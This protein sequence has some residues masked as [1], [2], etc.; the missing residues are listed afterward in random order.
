MCRMEDNSDT[1][2]M[3]FVEV[4]CSFFFCLFMWR[5]DFAVKYFAI[6]PKPSVTS[7][8]SLKKSNEKHC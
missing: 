3:H 1:S 2:K 5:C 6:L 8:H 7:Y 4:F